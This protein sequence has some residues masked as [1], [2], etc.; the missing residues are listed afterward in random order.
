[1][2]QTAHDKKQAEKDSTSD[3]KYFSGSGR[4]GS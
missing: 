1:M 2:S 4:S 3:K